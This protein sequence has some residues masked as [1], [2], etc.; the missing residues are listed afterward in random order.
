[1][2]ILGRPHRAAAIALEPC[3]EERALI[4]VH[5]RLADRGPTGPCAGGE[6]A[7]RLLARGPIARANA[8][9][10]GAVP[11]VVDELGGARRRRALE[12]RG[13]A[14]V[15]AVP[16]ARVGDAEA[17]HVAEDRRRLRVPCNLVER[18]Q[19]DRLAVA[20]V[21]ERNEEP[22][23][24]ARRRPGAPDLLEPRPRAVRVAAEERVPAEAELR[25]A[26][27]RFARL[28]GEHLLE[29]PRRLP[30]LPRP[31]PGV[32]HRDEHDGGEVRG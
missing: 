17:A 10:R 2:L 11:G 25:P 8:R 12:R 26:D 13:R 23:E 4:E 30:P 14:A 9:P 27:P 28:A 16:V 19:A 5:E 31:Q 24:A 22:R 15:V 20:R 21:D 32:R 29:E 18:L 7:K 3:A 6:R 1:D